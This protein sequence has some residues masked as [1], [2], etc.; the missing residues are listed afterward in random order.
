M[1]LWKQRKLSGWGNQ[2]YPI[3][4]SLLPLSC[5][6][7][8]ALLTLSQTSP[9]LLRV[10]ITSLLKALQEKEKL[11]VTSNFSF[12]CSAFYLLR[13]LSATFNKFEIVVCKH[14]QFGRVLDLLFGKWLTHYQM[15]NF[16]LFQI[17][18]LC[19]RQFKIRRKWQKVIQS[20][21]KHSGKRKNCSLRAISPFPTV[22]SK[23]LFPRGV[24]N[25]IV[26]EWVKRVTSEWGRWKCPL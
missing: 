24:K 12:S 17:E 10:C 15:T 20:G 26:W 18:R 13:E 8:M 11:L 9:G 25:F 3:Q 4:N 16:R 23:G 14:I 6:G 22:F 7:E 19:R 1:V 2:I 21:R 5:V